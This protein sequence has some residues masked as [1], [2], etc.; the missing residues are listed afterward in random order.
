MPEA[1]TSLRHS[2]QLQSNEGS[3]STTRHAKT[4]RW[5]SPPPLRAAIQEGATAWEVAEGFPGVV[6]GRD[7]KAPSRP[8]LL[9]SAACWASFLGQLTAADRE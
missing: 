7:S 3:R 6:P 4:A 1:L 8:A 2:R 5:S 9:L